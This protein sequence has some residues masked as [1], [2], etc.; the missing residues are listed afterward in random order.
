MSGGR[1]AQ[2][3][4]L[5][6]DRPPTVVEIAHEVVVSLRREARRRDTTVERLARD[7]LDIIATDGLVGAV[8]DDG[9]PAEPPP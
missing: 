8:L 6:G 4:L 1:P 5:P 7:L 9:A 2:Q 3:P